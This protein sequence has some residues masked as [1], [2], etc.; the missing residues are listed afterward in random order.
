MKTLHLSTWALK[1]SDTLVHQNFVE[2]NFLTRING[3]W[4]LTIY[5]IKY[6]RHDQVLHGVNN[7]IRIFEIYLLAVFSLYKIK[8]CLSRNY[9]VFWTVQ[10]Y[11]VASIALLEERPLWIVPAR[12]VVCL[13]TRWA[14]V[15]RRSQPHGIF[16]LACINLCLMFADVRFSTL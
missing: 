8:V 15:R 14:S 3:M 7:G 12:T 10:W 9:L 2:G 11:L 1:L 4:Q 5:D 6:V 16:A 13:S